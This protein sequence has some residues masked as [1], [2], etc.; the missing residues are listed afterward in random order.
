MFSQKELL[1]ERGWSKGLIELLLG[2]PDKT[3]RNPVF[4]SKAPVKLW[5]KPRVI[6]AEE[7]PEFLAHQ[8]RR[9][10]YS[11]SAKAVAE[12]KRQELLDKV[13]ALSID[14][15]RWPLPTLYRAAVKEWEE[16]GIE[17][18]DYARHGSDADISTKNRWAINYIRRN[19]V[20][21]RQ[22]FALFR[23]QT[24][25]NEAEAA[26]ECKLYNEIAK[27]YPDLA[28][29]AHKQAERLWGIASIA[30]SAEV[31]TLEASCL[32]IPDTRLI[33]PEKRVKEG[34]LVQW[35]SELWLETATVLGSDW[36][37]AYQL[38]SEKWEEIIAGAFKRE[39]Y[40]EVILTP[41]P[42]P[43]F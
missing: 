15:E 21:S 24:G 10:R 19:L 17:R 34:L 32:I 8:R 31:V 6:A 26:L 7:S 41:S 25:I 22:D 4:G 36:K 13:S 40:D 3:A 2:L 12:R 37:Q 11:V 1:N 5:G 38:S 35:T 28:N 20:S 39:K 42:I 23:G 18:G 16:I 9:E 29:A 14:V 27:A 43:S 30:Q 33:I